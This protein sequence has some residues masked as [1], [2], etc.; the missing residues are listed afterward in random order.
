MAT[1]CFIFKRTFHI[2]LLTSPKPDVT[3][4]MTEEVTEPEEN[5][6]AAQILGKLL[7]SG[8]ITTEMNNSLLAKFRKLHQAFVQS[9]TSEQTLLRRTR[10]LNKELKAQKLTIQNSAAQ[11]QEHRQTL[12]AL[13]QFV[14]NIQQ[15]LDA[16]REQIETTKANTALKRKEKEKLAAKVEK[17][18]DNQELKTEPEKRQIQ[19]EINALEE[20]IAQRRQNID[21]LKATSA[22]I[23]D[24]MAK[25]EETLAS[26]EKSKR[27]ADQKM[28]EIS[29]I[30]VKTRQKSSAVEASHNTMLTEEKSLNQQLATAEATLQQLHT[31]SHDLETEYQHITNDIEGMHQA[32]ADMR[33][34]SEDM[35]Q[36]CAERNGDKQKYEYEVRRLEKL[37]AEQNKEI[38]GLDTKIE[39]IGKDLVKKEHESQK[40][41]ETMAR[42]SLDTATLESQ[43]KTLTNEQAKEE[44]RNAGLKKELAEAM[45]AKEAALKAILAVEKVN[46]KV[47]ENIKKAIAEKDRRQGIHDELANKERE[48]QV[49]LT[50]ASLI[51]NRKAREMAGMKKKTVDAKALAMEKNL[52]Y[53]DLC[54]RK[55]ENEVKLREV[56]EMYE[57]VKLDRNKNVNHIQ[58]SK[59][60]IVE[61]KEKIRILENE[62]EVL[63]GEFEAV[64]LAV[65]LQKSDLNQAF[66]RRDAT[67]TDLKR[68]E[69]SY[70]ELQA[71]IDLQMNE[72]NRMN[73]ILQNLEDQ[74]QHHQKRYTVQADDCFN[75]QRMLIDKQDELCLIY[76]QF[77]RHEEVMKRGEIALREREEEHKLLSLQLRDFLRQIDVMQRKIPQ[78][79]A[80]ED[81]IAELDLQLDKE[82]SECDEITSKLEVP[83]LKERKRAY[84]GKDF[85]MKELEDKVSLYEQRIN[86]KE[87]QVWEK[88]ILLREIEDKIAELI[89][90]E[91]P[92]SEKAAKI[93]E[94]SG[95]IRASA[96]T[97]RR[98]K[99]AALAESAIYQAQTAELEDEKQALREELEKAGERTQ[100]GEAFDEYAEKVIKLYQRDSAAAKLAQTRG[101]NG[102]D[103]DDEDEMRK[104]GR[105]HFDA[106]PT[107]DGLSR[108]YGAFPVFQPGGPS[109]QLRHY[110]REVMRPIE[111]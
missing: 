105:Q 2:Q 77:N 65:K 78:L 60:L 40:L 22:N 51:R 53:M 20:A 21:S 39:I 73:V 35:R 7:E 44:G 106:Y 18:R 90:T 85:T 99:L 16:T 66:K 4:Q 48:L 93:C 86:S 57:K 8:Q 100:R 37:I 103:S 31:E 75:I 13:R 81:E 29:S 15:E 70:K 107:A 71:K 91:R 109:G 45:Q 3:G 1:N 23:Q 9:C 24:R 68:T 12:I 95:N 83:D 28:L 52:D 43:L 25:C 89:A 30:P 84:C 96:M 49:Q 110:R 14:T 36:K 54:R 56:S 87:Q 92:D 111:L 38:T 88:Q 79:K 47:M 102:W 62:V 72:T 69:M 11:Q 61:Y 80:Y 101:V 34:K 17:A 19:V 74:I 67:K 32:V 46:H 6:P 104:P 108:P 76:E 10:D 41:D 97:I 64:E 63:R 98:K 50:E 42:L 94:R 33:L 82:R 59:Q 27:A 5:H 26:I 55:E 58:T